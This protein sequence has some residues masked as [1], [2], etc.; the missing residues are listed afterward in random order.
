MTNSEIRIKIAELG[1]WWGNKENIAWA[2][3][4]EKL[5]NWPVSIADAWELVEEARNENV[6]IS[7]W[8]I[9]YYNPDRWSYEATLF[10]PIG[11]A[12]CHKFVAEA[13]TA[14]HAICLA[15]INWK[16]SQ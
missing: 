10:D 6:G 1:G 16:E 5:P 2:I 15:W 4:T 3:E 7:I 14:P 8:N 13:D 11:G 12:M 9:K